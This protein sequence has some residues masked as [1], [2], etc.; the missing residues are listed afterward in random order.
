MFTFRNKNIKVDTPPLNIHA[1][2][3]LTKFETKIV[4]EGLN[5]DLY[6][7]KDNK[8]M[9]IRDRYGS[10]AEPKFKNALS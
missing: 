10:D 8:K 6:I 2:L 1:G 9:C 7:D 5:A 3:N 4:S